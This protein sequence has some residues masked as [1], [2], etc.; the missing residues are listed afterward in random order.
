M[1]DQKLKSNS[2]SNSNFEKELKSYKLETKYLYD[3]ALKRAHFGYALLLLSS[4]ANP[5]S[6]YINTTNRNGDTI[7][8]YALRRGEVDIAKNLFYMAGAD[9]NIKNISGISPLDMYKK[10]YK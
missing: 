3:L 10:L 8:H 4:G 1:S 5:Q 9:I 6:E 2:K 7:V